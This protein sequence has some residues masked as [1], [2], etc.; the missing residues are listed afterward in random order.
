VRRFKRNSINHNK[1]EVTGL[2][3][4]QGTYHHDLVISNM[5]IHPTYQ[6]IKDVKKNQ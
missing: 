1:S 2:T 5:D 3:T 6:L 4:D